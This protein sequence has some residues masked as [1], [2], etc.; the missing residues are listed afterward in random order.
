M[1]TAGLSGGAIAGIII[2]SVAGA[3]LLAALAVLLALCCR[4]RRRAAAAD[5]KMQRPVKQT[6]IPVLKTLQSM[7]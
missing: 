3:A 1:C 7:R 2:G 6:S 4:R 5:G